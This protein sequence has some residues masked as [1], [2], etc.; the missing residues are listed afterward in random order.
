[1]NEALEFWR[2]NQ[3][4]L[5]QNHKP[6]PTFAKQVF[7]YANLVDPKGNHKASSCNRCYR[8]AVSALVRWAK[9]QENS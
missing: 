4:I 8:S 7:E 2:E 5:L 3:K 9:K 1:M 6:S